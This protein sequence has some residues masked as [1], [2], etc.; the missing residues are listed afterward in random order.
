MNR[1]RFKVFWRDESVGQAVLI[2]NRVRFKPVHEFAADIKREATKL[3]RDVGHCG[4][5]YACE[6]IDSGVR[7][8]RI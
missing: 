8:E 2:D 4:R 3:C 6:D 1:T 7:V 5:F